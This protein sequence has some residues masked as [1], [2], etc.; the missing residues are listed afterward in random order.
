MGNMMSSQPEDAVIVLSPVIATL[1]CHVSAR[2]PRQIYPDS[3][4]SMKRLDVTWLGPWST[5]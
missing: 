4:V 2:P 5:S 3:A 1:P